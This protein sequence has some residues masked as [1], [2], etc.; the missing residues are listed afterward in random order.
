M[1]DKLTLTPELLLR[2]YSHGYF[3]MADNAD[4][5]DVSIIAPHVRGIIPIFDLHIPQR[6]ARTVRNTPLRVSVNRAFAEVIDAC[7]A[8]RTPTRTDTWINTTIRDVYIDAHQMGFAHSVEVWSPEHKL[9]GG[10]YGLSLGQL[11]CGESMFSTQRDAS[12]IALVH[13]CARLWRGGYKMLDAQFPNSHLA[14]F[15]L[16]EM[17]QDEYVAQIQPL[18]KAEADFNC[19]GFGQAGLAVAYLD[20]RRKAALHDNATGP[21]ILP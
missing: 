2:L 1:T 9:V 10:L 20:A 11:F 5:A 4:T 15:G 16:I 6:L 13:L 17:P 14:Q 18:I 7:A 12:K 8:M 3:P 19:G 21:Q